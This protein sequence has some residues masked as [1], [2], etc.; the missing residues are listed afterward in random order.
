MLRDTL[1]TTGAPELAAWC[2]GQVVGSIEVLAAEWSRDGDYAG[3]PAIFIDLTLSKPPPGAETWP[4]DDVM[5][6]YRLV[7]QRAEELLLAEWWHVRVHSVD[8]EP[9]GETTD[10]P[11]DDEEP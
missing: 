7:N 2:V 8:P 9:L 1:F 3:R 10:G 11:F 6:L 5:R 4:I